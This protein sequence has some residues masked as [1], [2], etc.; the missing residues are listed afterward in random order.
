MKAPDHLV[1]YMEIRTTLDVVHELAAA[2]E[3]E[4]GR[5][6]IYSEHQAIS[7]ALDHVRGLAAKSANL[8]SSFSICRDVS[9][10]T[11]QVDAQ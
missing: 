5:L 6:Q 8:E 11:R 3:T 7:R 1:L 2:I 4:L 10:E 9:A